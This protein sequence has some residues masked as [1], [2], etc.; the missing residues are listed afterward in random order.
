MFCN[1]S[2]TKM[3]NFKDNETSSDESDESI[4]CSEKENLKFDIT[5]SVEEW[6]V[7]QPREKLYQEKR[8]PKTYKIMTPYEWS[9]VVQ[10]HFFLHTRLPCSLTFKK[11]NVKSYGIVY[12]SLVGRCSDCGSMFKGTVDTIPASG[13]R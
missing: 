3:S 1:I 5:F 2:E 13:V 4:S 8:G 10:D 9:N 7:I 6:E 11:A 12:L